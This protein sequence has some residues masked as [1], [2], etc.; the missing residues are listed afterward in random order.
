[1]IRIV[2]LEES[3]R[4]HPRRELIAIPRRSSAPRL[5]N[6]AAPVSPSSEFYAFAYRG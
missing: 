2:R 5:F 6:M 4:Q 1:M 3:E